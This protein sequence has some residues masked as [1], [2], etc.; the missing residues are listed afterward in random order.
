MRGN[1]ALAELKTDSRNAIADDEINLE[2]PIMCVSP[3]AGKGFH[4]H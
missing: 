1:L 3:Q 4:H 2:N